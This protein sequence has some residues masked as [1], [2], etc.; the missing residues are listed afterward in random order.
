MGRFAQFELNVFIPSQIQ[1]SLNPEELE[2]G[3]F[4]CIP[5]TAML[6]V[7]VRTER[8]KFQLSSS[9][10]PRVMLIEVDFPIYYRHFMF[11]ILTAHKL[12][13]MTRGISFILVPSRSTSE[14]ITFDVMDRDL[15]GD[16]WQ[17]N[18]T[19]NNLK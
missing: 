4:V 15:Q 14:T 9:S 7:S 12:V 17:E 3:H 5:I 10:R 13:Y 8:T 6:K 18:C 11:K 1:I 16:I 19:D 2:S